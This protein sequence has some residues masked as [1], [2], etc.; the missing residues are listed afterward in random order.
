M[1]GLSV[2][3]GYVS[4]ADRVFNKF[5]NKYEEMVEIE[6]KRKGKTVLSYPS[7]LCVGYSMYVTSQ[8]QNYI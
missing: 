3:N 4:V 1:N 6:T 2:N 8:S 5:K 7:N